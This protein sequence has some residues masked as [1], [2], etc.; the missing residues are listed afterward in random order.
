MLHFR[1]NSHTMAGWQ[2]CIARHKINMKKICIV[3][4]RKKLQ[5]K[6]YSETI[7]VYYFLFYLDIPLH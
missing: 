2:D 3:Y 6:F 5:I 4:D 1:Y 7:Q